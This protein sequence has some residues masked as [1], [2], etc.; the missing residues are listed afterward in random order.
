MA[1]PGSFPSC[2]VENHLDPKSGPDLDPD[3]P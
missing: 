3:K 2:R 1:C